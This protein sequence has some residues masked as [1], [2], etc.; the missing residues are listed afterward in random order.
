M[1]NDQSQSEASTGPDE[2]VAVVRGG[3]GSVKSTTELTAFTAWDL[4]REF[5]KK[6]TF[7]THPVFS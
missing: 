1:N 4:S 5:I 6:D 2:F 7:L 3:F